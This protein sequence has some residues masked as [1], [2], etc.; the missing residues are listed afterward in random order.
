LTRHFR[1]VSNC[2]VDDPAVVSISWEKIELPKGQTLSTSLLIL[3]PD[4][5]SNGQLARLKRIEQ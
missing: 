4:E 1:F 5:L 3:T 2:G